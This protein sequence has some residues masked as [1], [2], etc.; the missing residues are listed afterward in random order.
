MPYL[1]ARPLTEWFEAT[2]EGRESGTNLSFAV[3]SV[4]AEPL[5]AGELDTA[6]ISSIAWVRRPHLTYAPGIAVA[7]EGAV[8]S[9]RVLSQVPLERIKTVALDDSSLTS[10]TLTKILLAERFSLSPTYSVEPPDLTAMLSHADAALLIG[11]PGNLDYDPSL[12]VLDL[13]A[14]WTEWTGLPFV[15]ALWVGWPERLTPERL[16]LLL[17]AKEWGLA[18]RPE[19]AARRGPEHGQSPER[20]LS[21]MTE[22]IRYDLGEREEAGLKLFAEKARAH[23]LG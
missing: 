21:Y 6:L 3:P 22:A 10:V 17:R 5:A 1:N 11:D 2:E 12:T 8:R 4:L 19:I 14:A 18:H 7:S 9:V 13:G 20:A 16:A 23:G 15:Y